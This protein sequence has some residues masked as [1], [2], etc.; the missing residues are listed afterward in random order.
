[1][2]KPLSDKTVVITGATSG[3]GFAIAQNVAR[4]GAHVIGVGRSR[5]RAH[6][7]R[8][9]ILKDSPDAKI[10][11]CIADLSLQSEVARLAGDI[12][13]KVQESGNQ[14]LYGLVNNA[15]MFTY[16][17]TLTPEGFET[18]W[19]VNHLAAFRLSLDLLPLLKAAPAARILTISS[20]SHFNTK[21]NWNDIQ[22]RR[23]YNGLLAYQQTKLANVLFTLQLNSMLGGSSVRAFAIDPGLVKTDIGAK[24]NPPLIRWIWERR[25]SGG[26]SPEESAEGI[27][28]LISNPAAKLA[29][30]VYWKD[31][32]PVPPSPAALDAESAQR[33]WAI[34][35]QM[36][37]L[38]V[39]KV[40]GNANNTVAA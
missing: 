22:L 8:A 34:S 39:E 27:V 7:A 37:G 38:Q 31:G 24:N 9:K 15:A 3:I 5:E 35:E 17:L 33:L 4:L 23:R 19:A 29:D 12:R 25:A 2:N 30:G 6:E 11:Y 14:G 26:V 16:W 1:M 28:K 13:G 20:G 32:Q 40:N 18:Q 36:C 10:D 21:L